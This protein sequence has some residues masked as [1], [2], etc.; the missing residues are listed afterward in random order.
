LAESTYDLADEGTTMRREV[1]I[2]AIVKFA[3]NSRLPKGG[4]IPIFQAFKKSNGF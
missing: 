3:D 2:F 4:A 1:H